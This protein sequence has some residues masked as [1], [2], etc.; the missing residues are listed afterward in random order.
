MLLFP[1][2]FIGIF[3]NEPEIMEAGVIAM[4]IYFFGFCFMALQFSGQSTFVALG[5]A[6]YAITFSL[7]RKV[8]I[9]VPLTLLFPLIPKVGLYGVF[10]A[11]PVSNLIGGCACFFTMLMVIWKKKLST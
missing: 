1:K 10:L 4:H 6:K 8:F 3:N 7:L 9:V 11:E 2:F 5:Q